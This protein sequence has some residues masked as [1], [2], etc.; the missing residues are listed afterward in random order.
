MRLSRSLLCAALVSGLL[1]A[2]GGTALAECEQ[3]WMKVYEVE[4]QAERRT[5][6]VGDTARVEATVTRQDTG[7][8]VEDAR[9]AVIVTNW[10][11]GW[12]FGFDETDARGRATATF[13]LRRNR[14]KLGPVNLLALVYKETADVANCVQ[15]AEY[16][17]KRVRNA[18]VIER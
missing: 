4:L 5:Y 1:V 9:F 6:H 14:V 16:G 2:G 18:F 7:A 13:K 3:I 12:L 15:V 10:R 17:R 8:P 11:K